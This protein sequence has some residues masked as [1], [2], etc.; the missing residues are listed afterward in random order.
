MEGLKGAFG[1]I[2]GDFDPKD[3]KDVANAIQ[4]VIDSLG[5][6]ADVTKGM[7]DIMSPVIQQII[8]MAQAFNDLDSDTKVLIGNIIEIGA[9][10]SIIAGMTAAMG[11]AGKGAAL[12]VG[13]FKPLTTLAS[14]GGILLPIVISIVGGKALAELIYSQVPGLKELDKKAFTATVDIGGTLYDFLIGNAVEQVGQWGKDVGGALGTAIKSA[15]GETTVFDAI[16][17][18][19]DGMNLELEA[20]VSTVDDFRDVQA[21]WNQLNFETTAWLELQTNFDDV[22]SEWDLLTAEIESK[23]FDVNVETNFDSIQSDWDYITDEIEKSDIRMPVDVDDESLD[24][25]K[26]KIKQTFSQASMGD[27]N[28]GFDFGDNGS[29]PVDVMKNAFEV[30]DPIPAEDI[31]DM[32]GLADLFDKIKEV[33]GGSDQRQMEQALIRQLELRN[34]AIAAQTRLTQTQAG[35]AEQ[36]ARAADVMWSS[37]Q[38]EN[39]I[40]LE[41][42]GVEPEIEAFMWKILKKIQVRANESGQEFLLAAAS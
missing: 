19:F 26:E 3:P 42:S 11:L 16:Q 21:E 20:N 4:F 30:M 37:S 14:G 18:D 24:K 6:L 22:Q 34:Q 32:S 29:G 41:A 5:T 7:V 38:N 25:A 36:M 35:I 13:S 15:F 8:K 40:K 17:S 23:P 33:G 27:I 9:I 1:D 10:T 12:L 39:I 2:F 28:L 31:F